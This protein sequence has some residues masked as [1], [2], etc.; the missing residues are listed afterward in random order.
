MAENAIEAKL[1]EDFKFS[2]QQIKGFYLSLEAKKASYEQE[3]ADTMDI[4][5]T[6]INFESFKKKMLAAKRG[7]IDD[8]AASPD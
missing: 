2:E 8:E 1:Q 6:M 4:L 5:F 7:M 3:N